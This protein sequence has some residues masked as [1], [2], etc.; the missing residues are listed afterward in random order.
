MG[1]FEIGKTAIVD[2]TSFDDVNYE[3]LFAIA[4]KFIADVE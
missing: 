3:E 1:E 4:E 2:A